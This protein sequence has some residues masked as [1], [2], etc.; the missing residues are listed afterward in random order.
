MKPNMNINTNIQPLADYDGQEA[1]NQRLPTSNSYAYLGHLARTTT[2]SHPTMSPTCASTRSNNRYPRQSFV[3]AYFPRSPL[4]TEDVLDIRHPRPYEE[5]PATRPDPVSSARSRASIG[6]MRQRTPSL[7]QSPLIELLNRST[8]RYPPQPG[9]Q[10]PGS[11]VSSFPTLAPW[12]P[13]V[14]QGISANYQGNREG[15]RNQSANIDPELS[16]SVVSDEEDKP[17]F[18]R[19]HFLSQY[20]VRCSRI[21]HLQPL[22]HKPIAHWHTHSAYTTYTALTILTLYLKPQRKDTNIT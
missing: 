8:M 13:S 11:S 16:T 17:F 10:Q 6:V 12:S 15:I 5:S 22:T 21:H 19:N 1:E 20:H 3:E 2:P 4:L 14:G 18:C 9:M 7:P